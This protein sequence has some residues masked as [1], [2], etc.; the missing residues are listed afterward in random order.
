MYQIAH[1]PLDYVTIYREFDGA[2]I[3]LDP[4]N[5]DYQTYLAWVAEGNIAEEWSSDAS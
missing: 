2:W 5:S 1:F 3:P 4:A